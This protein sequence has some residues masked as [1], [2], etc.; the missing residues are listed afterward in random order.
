ERARRVVH[1]LE[2]S[3]GLSRGWIER[4]VTGRELVMLGWEAEAVVHR[5]LGRDGPSVRLKPANR[6][7]VL[8]QLLTGHLAAREEPPPGGA[9]LAT[10]VLEQL[11][12]EPARRS[13]DTPGQER[14]AQRFALGIGRSLLLGHVPRLRDL[15][16]HRAGGA[17]S[18]EPVAKRQRRAAIV[19]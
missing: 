2:C 4:H 1:E 8:E 13:F 9:R 12:G 7:G 17:M 3:G 14:L 11:A 6:F 15:R 16:P 18:Q 10:V 5:A 19:L